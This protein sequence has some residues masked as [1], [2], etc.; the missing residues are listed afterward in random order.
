[1]GKDS[2]MTRRHFLEAAGLAVYALARGGEKKAL[3]EARSELDG[4]IEE[5][6]RRVRIPGMAVGLIKNDRIVWSKGYGY[7]D[8]E[9]KIEMT[10]DHVENIGSISKTFVTTALMQLWER[11]K[12]KLSDDVNS[13]LPFAVKNPGY[14]GLKVTFE[15]LLTHTSSLD[16]GPAYGDSYA[17]GDPRERLE[18]WHRA[19]FT[20]GGKYYDR[21]KNFHPWEPGKG[22]PAEIRTYC[23]VA[24]GLLALLVEKISD[25]DF[26]TYCRTKI[27]LPL[28]MHNTSWYIKNIDLSTHAVP[29]TW[30]ENR[31]PRGPQ[32]GGRPLGVIGPGGPGRENV[33]VAEGHVA[34]CFYSHPNFPDGF[35]RCSVNQLCHYT[36]AY[37][38]KGVLGEARILQEGT[39]KTMLAKR[40]LNC[41]LCWW[42]YKLSNGDV[43]WGHLGND[44]GINNL[45]MFN[46]QSGTGTVLLANTNMGELGGVRT[47]IATRVFEESKTMSG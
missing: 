12:F 27:F 36:R 9:K 6:M 16:D 19:Y 20:P 14:P 26:E 42:E 3:A 25:Q 33:P 11:R 41:G 46:P 18:D 43:V 40:N 7:A 15:H 38:N 24:F 30:V 1:M 8:L 45:L 4:F 29:Y 37:L 21:E 10:V 35:L 22:Q 34:N 47:D 31:K 32:W 39:I 2:R 28:G 23:N 5:G 13:Y 17:C 44:P